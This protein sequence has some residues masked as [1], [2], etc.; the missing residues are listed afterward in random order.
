M[1]G[2]QRRV[3]N[4]I[5]WFLEMY[6]KVEENKL[7]PYFPTYHTKIELCLS[8]LCSN[9]NGR[10]T[11]DTFYLGFKFP[12]QDGFIYVDVGEPEQAVI[13]LEPLD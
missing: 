1:H 12:T 6:R 9:T 11:S 13:Y 8:S 2:T 10:K 5:A 3:V 7:N 4:Y